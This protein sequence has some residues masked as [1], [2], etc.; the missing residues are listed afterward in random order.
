LKS[1]GK[2][3][4]K[5]WVAFGR[6]GSAVQRILDLARRHR[7]PVS[8]KDRSSLD[9]K[10][11]TSKHQGVLALLSGIDTLA[12]EPFLRQLPKDRQRFIVLL[13]EI[14]DPHNLGAIIR[15]AC[16][17]GVE[18]ILLPKHRTSPLTPAAVKASAGA[19]E[20]VPVVRVGN[21]AQALRR[22]REEGVLLLGAEPSGGSKIFD[23]DLCQD[24]CLVVGG[25]AKGLRP[26]LRKECDGIVSIPMIGPI[27]SMNASVA[28]GILFYEVV[29]QRGTK[30]LRLGTKGPKP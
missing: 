17:A 22:I 15:T 4:E 16:A 20:W 19:I 30:A 25:E 27:D 28:A 8:F 11:G 13:D 24:V 21:A 18:G 7:I 1:K 6:S 3:T 14:Q 2:R 26:V 10:T 9:A 29:R 12:L 23:M 5:I